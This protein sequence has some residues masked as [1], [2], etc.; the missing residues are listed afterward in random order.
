MPF[1][2]VDQ[3]SDVVVAR[4]NS[5]TLQCSV[6]ANFN[7]NYVWFKDRDVISSGSLIDNVRY[8]VNSDGSLR[9]QPLFNGDVTGVYDCQV[10]TSDSRRIK[11]RAA[12][13]SVAGECLL[14]LYFPFALQLQHLVTFSL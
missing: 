11:S 10:S 5:V 14:N 6:S 3:P 9:I 1:R 2:F 13:V 12:Y 4:G 8:T 7:P